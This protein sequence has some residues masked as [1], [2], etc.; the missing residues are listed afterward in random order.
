M[1]LSKLSQRDEFW[2][3]LKF[4]DPPGYTFKWVE[5]KENVWVPN[6]KGSFDHGVV[7]RRDARNATVEIVE[8]GQV[9]FHITS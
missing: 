2:N 8:T 3:Y 1:E 4:Q 9:S 7:K 5:G 6:D